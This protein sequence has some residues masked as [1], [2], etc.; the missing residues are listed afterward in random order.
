MRASELGVQNG[1]LLWE[2]RVVVPS[3]GREA[4]LKFCIRASGMKVLARS[5]FWQPGF[6]SEVEKLAKHCV[7]CQEMLQSSPLGMA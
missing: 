5:H 1:C 7:P 2:N 3:A 4:L 6:D